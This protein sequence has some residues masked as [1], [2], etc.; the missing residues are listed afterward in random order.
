MTRE[1]FETLIEERKKR[2]IYPSDSDQTFFKKTARDIPFPLFHVRKSI[3]TDNYEFM[4]KEKSHR[5]YITIVSRHYFELWVLP[6]DE[7]RYGSFVNSNEYAFF[8]VEDFEKS[9]GRGRK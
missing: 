3:T 5:H 6:L 9:I 1:E 2:K 4:T 7:Q 8:R